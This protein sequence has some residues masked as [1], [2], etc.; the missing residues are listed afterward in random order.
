MVSLLA[1]ATE[2]F[3]NRKHEFGLQLN[4]YLRKNA[5]LG[6]HTTKSTEDS[7]TSLI[8]EEKTT[9]DLE[10]WTFSLAMYGLYGRHFVGSLESYNEVRH[11]LNVGLGFLAAP[12][13]ITASVRVGWDV[14]FGKRFATNVALVALAPSAVLVESKAVKTKAGVGG[15]IA[16]SLNY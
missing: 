4:T 2:K 8:A 9:S 7:S 13:Y 6:D 3:D 1:R 12:A 10:P 5:F 15:E 11:A 14:Y 16:I